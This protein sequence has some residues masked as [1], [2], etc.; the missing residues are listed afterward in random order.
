MKQKIISYRDLDSFIKDLEELRSWYDANKAPHM[1]FQIFSSILEK[2]KLEPVWNELERFFPDTPWFGNST[3]GN[4]VDCSSASEIVVAATIFEKPTSMFAICQYDMEK[5]SLQGLSREILQFVKENPWV[6]CVEIFRTITSVSSSRLCEVLDELPKDI[7]VL[8]GVVCSP[9]IS[10]SNSCVF[11]SVGGYDRSGLLV[12]FF[13]GEEFHIQTVKIRGWKPIGRNFMVTRAENNILYEL[14]GMPAFEVYAKYLNIKNDENFFMNALDF[15]IL[16]EYH[17]TTITRS[18]ASSNPDGS[19]TMASDIE[20]ASVVRLSYGEPQT[21]LSSVYEASLEIKKF[22]PDVLQFIDCAAR[23]AFWSQQEPTY[24]LN[25]FKNMAPSLGFFSHGEFIR[26]K[27]YVNQHNITLVVAAMR[28]GDGHE[29]EKENPKPSELGSH[30]L[31]LASRMATFIRE[32]SF[33]LEEINSRLHAMNSQLQ[34][35]ATTDALTGLEN[36][37]SF[38]ELLK[39]ISGDDDGSTNWSMLMID[40]N[41]LKYTNDTFGHPAGDALIIAAARSITN[42]FGADGKCFRIGGDEFVV[43]SDASFEKMYRLIENLHANIREYNKDALYHLSVAV[44]ESRLLNNY[45]VRK[46]ISDWKMEADLNM[47]QD[48]VRA[49]RSRESVENTNLKELISC[50]ISIEEAKDAYTAH[51]S[52]RVRDLSEMLARYLGLSEN[53]I[54]LITDAAQLH[55]IGKVGVSDAIL[56]KPGKLTD[57]EFAIIKQH[58]VIGAKILMRSNYTQELVQIVLHHHERYD[59]KGYPEG[60]SG[61]DIPIGARIIAVADSIDAMTSK[62]VYRDAMSLQFCYDEIHKNLGKMYD[63]AIGQVALEHWDEIKDVLLRLLS[64]APRAH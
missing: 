2:E 47:Y 18:P 28:E 8:G 38:D 3:S 42:A 45:G 7:Q 27:D 5:D 11:S 14:G 19:L 13:G 6:K 23:K 36:R 63:P 10:S 32:T 33:E 60:I 25:P 56:G 1:Y 55:D 15:P 62:R 50:M 51:H 29:A 61:T 26:E 21:I 31:P 39:Q 35:I 57:E 37:L 58:T 53:N 30:K 4:I 46:S 40:V 20:E 43:V 9:D 44:G 22:R 12:A 52:D 54:R 41:G 59:G 49:H 17:G 16:Y 64:G 34:N 24:E 48:K